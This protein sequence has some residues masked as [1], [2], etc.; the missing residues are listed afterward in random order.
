MAPPR[1]RVVARVLAIVVVVTLAVAG[2]VA[3]GLSAKDYGTVA[4]WG[5]PDH[6]TY[7]GRDYNRSSTS[8]HGTPE[9]FVYLDRGAPTHWKRIGRTFAM[10]PIYATV[11]VQPVPGQLC[12]GTLYVP[13]HRSGSYVSYEL[14][15]GP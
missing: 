13:T 15:G 11:L 6:I 3:A 2:F 12:A 4:F 14:S 10:H 5:T 8:V 7:C 9:H 1:L